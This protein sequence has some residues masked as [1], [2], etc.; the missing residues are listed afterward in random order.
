MRFDRWID[1]TT[2]HTVRA[3]FN[4]LVTS[5][6]LSFLW[7]FILGYR[8]LVGKAVSYLVDDEPTTALIREA[9][10]MFIVAVALGITFV[11]L[12]KFIGVCKE[13]L[14]QKEGND[15]AR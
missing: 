5:I 4:A 15:D 12:V 9:S 14:R 1:P 7:L 13:I 6:A 3:V 11:E 10:T 2:R 8:V